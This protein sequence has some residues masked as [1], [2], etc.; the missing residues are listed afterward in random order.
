MG[1]AKR[2]PPSER[3]ETAD[4]LFCKRCG[5]TKEPDAFYSHPTNGRGRQYWCK[6]CCRK[7]RQERPKV[8][9]DP[10][11]TRR[12]KL[13]SYGITPDEYDAMYE[14]QQG[15]CAICRD[16]KEPWAPGG[17]VA[18]R[19]RF[20]VV[21]HDHST[22]V[23]RGLLCWNCNCGIGQFREDPTVMFAAAAYLG[24]DPEPQKNGH[25]F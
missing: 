4:K 21:D 25:L 12:Y 19:F 3:A 16:W 23:V 15:R 7:Q 14:K 20:L 6:E 11:V 24:W 8:Q 17:G 18:G 9:Q 2:L 10:T 5:E 1:L 13:W 22:K